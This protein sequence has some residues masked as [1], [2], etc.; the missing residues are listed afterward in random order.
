M[1]RYNNFIATLQQLY[2]HATATSLSRCRNI[3]CHAVII[4]GRQL[5]DSDYPPAIC[6]P[7]TIPYMSE[8][9]SIIRKLEDMVDFFIYLVF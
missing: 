4:N 8:I 9:Q 1:P 7:S 3:V 5:E 2:C 6:Q